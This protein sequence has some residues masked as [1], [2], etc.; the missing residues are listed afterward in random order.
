MGL[1]SFRARLSMNNKKSKVPEL[2]GLYRRVSYSE[3]DVSTIQK[4]APLF[5]RNILA[6]EIHNNN[7]TS[8][9]DSSKSDVT[10][11]LS[12]STINEMEERANQTVENAKLSIDDS[13]ALEQSLTDDKELNKINEN[14]DD[15]ASD[16]KNRISSDNEMLI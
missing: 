2:T 16:T 1:K 7:E 6:K 13:N 3:S 4:N 11:K 15:H 10:D 8:Q 9:N 12:S 5:R 14:Q